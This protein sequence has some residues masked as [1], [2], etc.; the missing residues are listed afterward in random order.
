MAF[1]VVFYHM[2]LRLIAFH[3]HTQTVQEFPDPLSPRAGDEIHPALRNRRVWVRDYYS[4]WYKCDYV[5]RKHAFDVIL[6]I[7]QIG[8]DATYAQGTWSREL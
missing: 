8:A 3:L 5:C 2:I 6:I 1:L 4:T 7:V